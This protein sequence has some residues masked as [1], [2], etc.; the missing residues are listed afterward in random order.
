V[1]RGS[2]ANLFAN[3][4]PVVSGSLQDRTN[5]H[6]TQAELQSDAVKGGQEE[7]LRAYWRRPRQPLIADPTSSRAYSGH[8]LFLRIKRRSCLRRST[9]RNRPSWAEL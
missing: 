8:H 5:T 7:S 4:S 6:S 9:C 2:F 3:F 1:P